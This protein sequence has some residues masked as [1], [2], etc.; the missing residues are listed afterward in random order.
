MSSGS[1]YIKNI[2]KYA[3]ELDDVLKEEQVNSRTVEVTIK[4]ERGEDNHFSILMNF[5]I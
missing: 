2:I 4:E 1:T 5:R 3:R